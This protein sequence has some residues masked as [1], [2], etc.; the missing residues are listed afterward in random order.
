MQNH[1]WFDLETFILSRQPRFQ[2][3]CHRICKTPFELRIEKRMSLHL[4]TNV[5]QLNLWMDIK[6][7]DISIK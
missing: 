1:G 2:E 4:K 6:T 7:W 5:A 3:T